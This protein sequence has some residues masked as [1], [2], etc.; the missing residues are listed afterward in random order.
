MRIL[1]VIVEAFLCIFLVLIAIGPALAADDGNLSENP[2]A[3]ET[4]DNVIPTGWGHYT[5]AG[6]S[7]WGRTEEEF[8]SGDASVF[9]TV[10][11]YYQQAPQY[12]DWVNHGVLFGQSDGYNGP[13]AF[14]M[15][16][17]TE[18]YYAF[19]IKAEDAGDFNEP[20]VHVLLRGW[21]GGTASEHRVGT[22]EIEGSPIKPTEEWTLYTGKLTSPGGDLKTGALFFQISGNNGPC[23]LGAT[24]YVDDAYLGLDPPPESITGKLA[25][26]PTGK[27]TSAWGGIK[28]HR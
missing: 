4:I 15:E 9:L 18:Y 3:E 14:S 10:T 13:D 8:R 28:D 22:D 20:C 11:G 25:V 21:A 27:L 12:V 6:T 17:D 16:E 1:N 5:G 23:K 7:D 26:E 2:G 19:W 24:F